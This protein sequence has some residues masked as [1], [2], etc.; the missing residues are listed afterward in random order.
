MLGAYMMYNES[1]KE[2][3]KNDDIDKVLMQ[4]FSF[5]ERGPSVKSDLRMLHPTEQ[6]FVRESAK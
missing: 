4:S 3:K 2:V 5:L 1:M 6:I